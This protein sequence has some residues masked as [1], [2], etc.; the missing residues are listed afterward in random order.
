MT[1]KQSKTLRAF[2]SHEPLTSWKRKLT[3][4]RDYNHWAAQSLF[5]HR[6]VHVVPQRGGHSVNPL[7]ILIVVHAVV[8][9]QGFEKVFGRLESMDH[10]MNGKVSGISC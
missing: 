10:V 3:I 2:T 7:T 4:N 9:P 5:F 1:N 6:P 8:D